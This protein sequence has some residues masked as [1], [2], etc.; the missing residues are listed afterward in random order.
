MKNT[1]LSIGLI[2]CLLSIGGLA[3]CEKRAKSSKDGVLL[4]YTVDGKDY[5]ITADEILEK[6]YDDSSKYQAIYDIIYSVLVKNYFNYSH[7]VE[8]Y[9]GEQPAIGKGQM[10]DI[11]DKAEKKRK[12][13]EDTARQNAE[14]NNTKYKKELE[15][16]LESKEVKTVEELEEKYVEELQKE[17][18][19]KNFYTYYIE[20]I[21]QGAG[22]TRLVGQS[23]EE[24]KQ[25]AK[26][27]GLDTYWTGYFKDQAPY[28]VSHILV[29]LE[30]G[31][32]TNYSTG[33]ISQANAKKLYDVVKA[34]GDGVDDF[35]TISRYS[36]DT[37]S[38]D[39]HG[40]LGIMDTSTSFVNEFKLGI[41]AYENLYG[42][43]DSSVINASKISISDTLKDSYEDAV[44]DSFHSSHLAT[45]NIPTID[46]SVFATL[47]SVKEI[48][49][50][51]SH[52]SVLEDAK[53][54]YPRNIIYN[55]YLNRHMVAF[56]TGAETVTDLEA[57]PNGKTGYVKY[58]A[59]SKLSFAATS[60]CFL[61]VKVNGDWRPVLCVRAGSDYQGVHFIVVNRSPFEVDAVEGKRVSQSEYYTTFYPDQTL[62]PHEGS[63][64]SR[65]NKKTYVNFSVLDSDTTSTKKRADEFVSKLNSFDSDR[66]SKY[67]FRKYMAEE[68]V[69]IK[70]EGIA[71]SFEK[72]IETSVEKAEEERNE[73]WR[74]TWNE[75][76]D[77]LLKQ[78]DERKKL[79][80]E[81]CRLVY[82]R[83]N[84]AVKLETAL[85]WASLTED[86]QDEVALL[87][88][89]AD[90]ATKKAAAEAYWKD[91][92]TK[93]SSEFKTKKGICNDGKDHL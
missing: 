13:D 12:D 44:L 35:D 17:T 52:E 63:G 23:E 46:E 51:E 9:Y 40:D 76:I 31:S 81:A 27:A 37:G 34:L 58:P 50:D 43:E 1:K 10:D 62:Y 79:I 87:F 53:E 49:K 28:H 38:R 89:G 24:A 45:G 14:N 16:I 4:T 59:T 64:D 15:T 69:K 93:V 42:S 75:Y 60:K 19:E 11:R 80:P 71:K 67:I 20:D 2:A 39:M 25:A 78:G 41:Y 54:F 26:D 8:Y 83:A 22:T 7:K 61:S 77:T 72:W 88:P 84:E 68:N 6:S 74:K 48:E 91:D 65:V 30:D 33:T 47:N 66:L 57:A 85:P 18:F 3:G 82:S 32:G 56:I 90:L 92:D 73:N 70:Q 36:E 86:Q 29:K 55:K 21:K 5:S